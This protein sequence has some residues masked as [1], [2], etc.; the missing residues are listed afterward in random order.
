VNSSELISPFSTH[1][2]KH[3]KIYIDESGDLG[4]SPKSSQ[5]Y[6]LAALI[7]EQDDAEI[8]RCFKQTRQRKLKK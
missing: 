4:F 6:I 2:L 7:L 5:F 3:L 8:R 1:L